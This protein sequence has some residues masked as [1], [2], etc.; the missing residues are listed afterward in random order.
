M[1]Q[2]EGICTAKDT[3]HISSYICRSD[4]ICDVICAYPYSDDRQWVAYFPAA[5]ENDT[6]TTF[7]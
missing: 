6:K 3:L 4:E 7:F 2:R 5:K 1:E